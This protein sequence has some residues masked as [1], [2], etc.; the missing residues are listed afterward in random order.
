MN[1]E[2]YLNAAARLIAP[3]LAAAGATMPDNFRVSCG[4][5]KGGRGN[6][7]IG[8]CWG[9]TSSADGHFELFISPVLADAPTVLSTL[10]HEQVHAAVGL[11]C[12]HKGAFRKVAKAL[13]LVGK[14]TATTAGP[15]LTAKL[16]GIASQLGEYPHA[17]MA[18]GSGRPKQSTRMIKCECFMCGYTAR[19]TAKWIELKGAPLCPCNNEPMGVAQ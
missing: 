1:R 14:M 12:G 7:R 19:T 17:A 9:T 5:P 4:W 13:G 11:A 2:A 18:A 16:A 10:A 6:K 8:E 3:L 15:E